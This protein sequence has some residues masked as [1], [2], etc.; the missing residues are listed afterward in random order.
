M[1]FLTD[2]HLDAIR[3]VYGRVRSYKAMERL[4]GVNDSS[5]PKYLEKSPGYTEV[6]SKTWGKLKDSF[7]ECAAVDG[8]GKVYQFDDEFLDIFHRM[9]FD[10]ASLWMKIGN[11][12]L[13]G[14][15]CHCHDPGQANAT[16]PTLPP[17]GESPMKEA[18]NQ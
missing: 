7:P 17:D 2:K 6:T 4:S 9:K 12:I 11:D 16:H 5:F 3:A 13:K 8:A 14:L 15:E 10:Q 18:I 1:V